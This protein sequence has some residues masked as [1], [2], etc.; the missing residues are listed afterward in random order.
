M[1]RVTW[2]SQINFVTHNN[3]QEPLLHF[4]NYLYHYYN[5]GTFTLFLAFKKLDLSRTEKTIKNISQL[6]YAKGLKLPYY[7]WP[8]VSLCKRCFTIDL[9]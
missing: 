1:F 7:Y 3:L 6:E 2:I 4:Y 9:I 8:A 5:H